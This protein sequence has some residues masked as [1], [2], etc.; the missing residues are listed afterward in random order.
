MLCLQSGTKINQSLVN[1]WINRLLYNIHEKLPLYETFSTK[2]MPIKNLYSWMLVRIPSIL[3][4]VILR[5][6]FRVYFA[7]AKH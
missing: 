5:E 7:D 4:P 2:V 3:T 1:K 6:V